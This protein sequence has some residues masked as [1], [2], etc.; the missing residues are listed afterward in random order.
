MQNYE[1]E[2]RNKN[3]CWF[4]SSKE[5]ALKAKS[6]SFIT[7]MPGV[8]QESAERGWVSPHVLLLEPCGPQQCVDSHKWAC[9]CHPIISYSD[10][11]IIHPSVHLS[12]HSFVY[13]PIYLSIYLSI[14]LS[15]HQS[16][17]PSIY[18]SIYP[19]IQLIFVEY[20]L[21]TGPW[22][23]SDTQPGPTL[24]VAVPNLFG[25]RDQFHGSQFFHGLVA[26]G[27]VS[28]WFKHI[29]FIVHFIS[30]IITLYN[31]P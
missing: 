19:S 15:I 2:I 27:M 1:H 30:I 7:F 17:W 3:E 23:P 8:I 4:E 29:T 12:I 9:E 6:S 16:I 13:L 24:K 14:C 11:W 26:G 22:R 18:P 5:E 21:C 20:L 10:G 31:S 28:G 25:T